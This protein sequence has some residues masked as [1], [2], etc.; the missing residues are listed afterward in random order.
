MEPPKTVTAIPP[1][2]LLHAVG[3]GSILEFMPASRSIAHIEYRGTRRSHS[4]GSTAGLRNGKSITRFAH[5][6]PT[7]Q[8]EIGVS[9]L[10]AARRRSDYN[11][12]PEEVD[13][14]EFERRMMRGASPILAM[15]ASR[16][17]VLTPVIR[18]ATPS[19]ASR[20]V[21]SG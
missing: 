7:W 13:G 4:A 15:E 16:D 12:V 17:I 3:V 20:Q 6:W 11:D 5:P 9:S 2:A 14:R 21:L 8:P 19:H 10:E 18:S 1:L